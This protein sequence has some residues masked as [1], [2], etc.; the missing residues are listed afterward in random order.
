V[1]AWVPIDLP[2]EWSATRIPT[3]APVRME[4]DDI[5]ALRAAANVALR[6]LPPS[7]GK[8]VAKELHDAADFGYRLG[9]DGP[10]RGL[11]ADLKDL[12]RKAAQA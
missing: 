7:I 11:L 12:Q 6:L 2:E 10:V 4:R 9:A 3:S 5:V 1:N 8:L